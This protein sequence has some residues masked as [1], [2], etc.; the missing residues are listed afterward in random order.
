MKSYTSEISLI[1]AMLAVK[2]FKI[3]ASWTDIYLYTLGIRAV[4]KSR[5]QE[6][7]NHGRVEYGV[8]GQILKL[9]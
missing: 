2:L 6:V 4:G 9:T 3:C 8:W 7:K 1:P 5:Y